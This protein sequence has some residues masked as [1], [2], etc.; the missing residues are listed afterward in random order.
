M[1]FKVCI[2]NPIKTSVKRKNNVSKTY[3]FDTFFIANHLMMQDSLRFL[4]LRE[5]NYTE[6][7]ELGRFCK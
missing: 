7:K 6:L 5:L 4:I 1:D 2:F 3:K